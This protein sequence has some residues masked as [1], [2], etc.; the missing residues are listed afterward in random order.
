MGTS[1]T[2][3]APELGVGTRSVP[4]PKMPLSSCLQHTK[5]ALDSATPGRAPGAQVGEGWPGWGP[6]PHPLPRAVSVPPGPQAAP[7]AGRCDIR[8]DM[9]VPVAPSPPV[10]VL[11][12]TYWVV[13]LVSCIRVFWKLSEYPRR[14]GDW[15]CTEGSRKPLGPKQ[16]PHHTSGHTSWPA[17][18][19]NFRI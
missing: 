5:R 7:P 11:Q 1:G 14:T 15:L 4:I 18:G 12:L 17:P 6:V 8:W 19:A 9:L 2:E 3:S 16:R 10:R 13:R